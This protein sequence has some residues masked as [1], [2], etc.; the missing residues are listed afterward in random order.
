MIEGKKIAVLLP[1]AENFSPQ[2]AGAIS[3]FTYD[4]AMYS[5]YKD[6]ITV[7][8]K[9]GVIPYETIAYQGLT[10]R[11]RWLLGRN[12]G[13]AAAFYQTVN[14]NPPDVVEIHN[15]PVVL[16]Y[17][18]KKLPDVK[19]MLHFHNDPQTISGSKTARERLRILDQAEAVCCVSEFTRHRFLE[20]LDC[21]EYQ[22]NKVRVIYNGIRRLSDTPP[23]K[24][25]M[26][27]YAGRLVE[28]KGVVELLQA[29][30]RVIPSYPAW[31][32]VI[33]GAGRHGQ[34]EKGKSEYEKKIYRIF[35][36]LG[37]QGEFLGHQPYSQVMRLYQKAS[38][39]VA[40]SKWD[41]PLGR[42]AIEALAGGCALI[43]SDRGGLKEINNG[44]GISLREV[45]VDEIATALEALLNNR[46][47]LVD[48]QATCW[49]SYDRF[50][51]E[52]IA[53]TLDICR[54][55]IFK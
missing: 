5:R 21:S 14:R 10:P 34:Y 47:R 13:L 41:E 48:I 28:E 33:A 25:N 18:K 3:L 17:L 40:P 37:S 11:C 39:V 24:E 38:I 6:A 52:T 46:E 50:R 27:L 35:D 2:K 45:S 1:Y 23:L 26:I 44:C 9:S 29:V 7:Y 31:K 32:F 16:L 30:E 4:M 15:R 22:R 54:D 42:T 8:G 53:E 51:I 49:E 12:V 19:L 43:S 36:A 55:V 20:G